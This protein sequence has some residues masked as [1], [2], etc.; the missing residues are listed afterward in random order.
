QNAQDVESPALH[1]WVI[2]SPVLPECPTQMPFWEQ[3]AETQIA[4]QRLLAERNK[5]MPKL[6]P[7]RSIQTS[8]L[9]GIEMNFEELD[10]YITKKSMLDTNVGSLACY[11][12]LKGVPHEYLVLNTHDPIR[13]WIRLERTGDSDT[14]SQANNLARWPLIGPSVIKL[15]QDYAPL[16]TAIV[17]VEE[18]NL[19]CK[20]FKVK[21]KLVFQRD[22]LPLWRLLHLLKAFRSVV[23]RYNIYNKNCWFFCSVVIENLN[24]FATNRVK[25]RKYLS[26]TGTCRN[27]IRQMFDLVKHQRPEYAQDLRTTPDPPEGS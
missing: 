10:K 6:T 18:A 21:E 26:E 16:D 3:M 13:A 19:I 27:D 7:P 8:S 12:D 25:V 5:K 4:L 11:R 2:S 15:A 20:P 14:G 1:D 23:L 24:E 22:Q 17:A 9:K